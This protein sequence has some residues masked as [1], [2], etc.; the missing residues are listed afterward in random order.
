MGLRVYTVHLPPLLSGNTTP[1]LISEGFSWGAFLLGVIWTLWH[2]LWIESAALLAL[3]LAVGVITDFIAL[4]EPIEAAILLAIRV[5]IGCSGND[6]RRESLHQRGYRDGGVV[7]GRGGEDAL[8]R[9]LD[10]RGFDQ[11]KFPAA[12]PPYRET[13]ALYP[14]ASYQAVS[15]TRPAAS[16]AQPPTAADPRAQAKDQPAQQGSSFGHP[17]N[18]LRDYR[19]RR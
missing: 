11:G 10:L 6:W 8:R 17:D 1:A 9:Y 18:A 14:A 4:S 7:V 12:P 3:F 13:A 16:T 19:P 2:R 5:L 15:A